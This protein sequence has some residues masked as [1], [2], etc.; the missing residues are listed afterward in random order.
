MSQDPQGP[1]WSS[2]N[3]SN[4]RYGSPSGPGGSVKRARQRVEAGLSPEQAQRIHDP[5][6]GG[7]ATP[8]SKTP[9]LRLGPNEDSTL[10]LQGY[11]QRRR[12]SRGPKPRL[13]PSSSGSSASTEAPPSASQ[14][15]LRDKDEIPQHHDN[16]T[17]GDQIH[18]KRPP[19]QRP[20]R[21][22]YVPSI[23]D[24]S[25]NPEIIPLY[26]HHPSQQPLQMQSS[27]QQSPYHWEGS[28][29]LS[30]NAELEP[31]G[32]A[33]TCG[34]SSR[35]S[36]S[37]SV[38][39]IPEFPTPANPIPHLLQ[40]RR[41]ANLGPPPSSRRG[42]SS[43]Y[44]QSSYV[45]PIPEEL[46]EF[47]QISHGSYA[48]SHVIPAIW[49]DGPPEHALGEE[50]DDPNEGE[51]GRESRGGAHDEST[52]LV[53]KASL[54][55]RHK[56][57]L[58]TIRSSE[59]LNND[60][61]NRVGSNNDSQA[62]NGNSNKP[63]LVSRV[64]VNGGEA[65]EI[66][67]THGGLSMKGNR[68]TNDKALEGGT[69]S[70]DVSSST[71]GAM[72]KAPNM[73]GNN[74]PSIAT[75]VRPRSPATFAMDERVR[76]IMGGLERGGALQSGTPSPAA[77]T[78]SGEKVIKRPPRLN[79]DAVKDAEARGSLTSLPDL[80]RRAT[81]L[82]SNLDRGR[83]ASRLGM[84]DMLVAGEATEKDLSRTFHTCSVL[85]PH[86][87]ILQQMVELGLAR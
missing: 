13:A 4:I 14:R 40:T 62:A 48:S 2:H 8:A 34:S 45:A 72:E 3:H 64:A 7:S 44:S 18:N 79:I 24:A 73:L 84:R 15:L 19:P 36:M 65:K 61:T 1:G 46:P 27:T 9:H 22:S 67:A 49:N 60:G 26:Q 68:S 23:L 37:S 32:A 87:N 35:P 52:G 86:A 10:P 85:F 81:K 21:P 43:Y 78:P 69:S 30:S 56:P 70:F 28:H 17:L 29:I 20:P 11:S 38:G 12:F 5:T 57:S 80:I 25:S 31:L 59:A 76:Q 71:N 82:A 74:N 66:L 6:V 83:T 33:D 58:T 77:G 42:A 16:S 47:T 50:D 55:K 41:S 51:D 54:G 39:S 53:R 63:K 75:E